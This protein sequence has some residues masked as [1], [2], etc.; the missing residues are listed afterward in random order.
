MDTFYLIAMIVNTLI[1]AFAVTKRIWWLVYL[2][3]LSVIYSF[4]WYAEIVW[5]LRK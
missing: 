4:I 2:S 5:K 1:G 3:T